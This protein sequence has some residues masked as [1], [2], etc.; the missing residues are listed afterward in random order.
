MSATIFNSTKYNSVKETLDAIVDDDLS[1]NEGSLVCKKWLK[2]KTQE[3]LWEE[4]LEM[5]GPGLATETGEG[6]EIEVGTLREGFITRYVARKFA[7]KMIITEEAMEDN[8]YPEA[9]RLAKRLNRALFKTFDIDNTNMLIRAANASYVG[10]DGVSLASAS[11]T[12]PSGAT[13]WSRML[14]TR[15]VM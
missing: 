14:R 2:T 15:G 8:K 1:D 13:A 6:T 4:D 11:H 10:G 3:D 12:L 9:I 7:L 5:G